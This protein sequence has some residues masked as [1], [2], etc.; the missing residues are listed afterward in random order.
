LRSKG[1]FTTIFYNLED[2]DKIFEGGPY[3]YNLV[4]LYLCFWIDR[5]CPKKENFTYAPVW[6]FLYSLP[7][8]FWLE[9]ILL[10]IGN[11]LGK[12]VKY[13]EATK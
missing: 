13:Y 5:F 1:F 10:G 8:E 4:G 9:E 11:T 7:Q 12:Y 2:K 6:I 3:F